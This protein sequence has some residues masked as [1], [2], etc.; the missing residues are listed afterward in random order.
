MNLGKIAGFGVLLF[1]LAGSLACARLAGFLATATPP[2]T[3]T[4]TATLT[5]TLTPTVTPTPTPDRGIRNPDNGHWYRVFDRQMRWHAARDY[6]AGLGAHLVT[7]E[8]KAEDQFLFRLNP[9]GWMGAT[10]DG[11]EGTWEWVT[12]EPWP[13]TH[14]A[15]GEPNNFCGDD[16]DHCV[17][18]NYLTYH[19]DYPGQWNDI[20][21]MEL[22]FTCEWDE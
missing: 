1:S 3:R 10:D 6:C 7:L 9:G 20:P 16:P 19:G 2:P 8:N 12:G 22:T 5:P 13:Y 11:H 4:P 17:P 18:E 21:D 14:W 15:P